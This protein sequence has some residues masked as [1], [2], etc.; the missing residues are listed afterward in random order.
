MAPQLGKKTG[1][2]RCRFKELWSTMRWSAQPDK[3]P[4]MLSLKTYRW[5]L[6]D[7]FIRNFNN[8][9]ASNFV[10]LE[11]IFVDESFSQWYGAGGNW[12]NAGFPMYVSMDRKPEDGCKIQDAACG[13]TSVMIRLKLVKSSREDCQDEE[14][15]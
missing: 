10:P 14:V 6:C 3:K 12:I 9:R 2:K 11:R 13:C 15:L 8:L 4:K 1:M 7:G 5:M